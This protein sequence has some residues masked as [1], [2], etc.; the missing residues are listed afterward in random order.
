MT[1]KLTATKKQHAVLTNLLRPAHF[2]HGLCLKAGV[3]YVL[4][5]PGM[6]TFRPTEPLSPRKDT[7]ILLRPSKLVK[8]SFFGK[9]NLQF[10]AF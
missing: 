9:V 7:L 3:R 1:L 5:N 2:Y 4:Q 10:Q 8:M 6:D